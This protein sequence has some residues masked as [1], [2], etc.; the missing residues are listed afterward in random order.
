MYIDNIVINNVGPISNF[1][2]KPKFNNDGSP[3]P[4]VI[5]GDN[6]KGKTALSS[7]VADSLI[8]IA[9]SNGTYQN[10]VEQ[11]GAF[12]K[13]I[14]SKNISN[15]E[16]YS[17]V[18]ISYKDEKN[19]SYVEKSGNVCI[20]NLKND[21]ISNPESTRIEG[22]LREKKFVKEIVGNLNKEDVEKIFN[23][24]VL[25]FFPSYRSEKPVW[26]NENAIKYNE[27]YELS[28]RV[29]GRLDKEILVEHSEERN[30]QWVH[31]VIVDSLIDIDKAKDGGNNF[32]INGNVSNQQLLKIA[33]TNLEKIL[34]L[35][36]KTD[37]LQ[38][39]MNYRNNNNSFRVMFNDINQSNEKDN[40]YNRSINSLKELSLG[41]AVLFNMFATIIRHADINDINNSIE[42]S[43]IQGVVI[44]DEIDMHLDSVMQ[45]EVLPKLLKLFPK[46]QFIITS[47]SPLF[48]LGMDREFKDEYTLLEMPNGT[49]IS[50]ERFSEFEKSYRY[51]NSTK[52]HEEELNKLVEEKINEIKM[53]THSNPLII[54]EGKTDWI[55]L[56]NALNKLKESGKYKDLTLDFLEFDY[57]MG[58][59]ELVKMKNSL[60]KLPQPYKIVLI[61]DRDTNKKEIQDFE[62]N[63]GYKNWN[64]NVYTFRIPIP[65]HRI[66]TPKICIEHFYTDEEIKTEFEISGIRKRL[67][68]ANEF[69]KETG[70]FLGEQPYR[71]KKIK[72]ENPIEII[73][74]SDKCKVT[75]FKDVTQT[76]YA[77][78]KYEFAKRITEC[79][80]VNYEE[81]SLIFDIIEKIIKDNQ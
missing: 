77:I 10:V 17:A 44:V 57:D 75:K 12:Y 20:E 62:T 3:L 27:I 2:F 15:G 29:S 41:Q 74:S 72:Y 37:K 67:F 32:I 53:N 76:N 52:K 5:I 42:L 22:K 69:Q 4:I 55:H 64:N 45:N 79:N 68:M 54:T 43:K 35:I 70:D 71:T 51:L 63:D 7:Y 56:K 36:L 28:Q 21:I 34:K 65:S 66:N 13:I 73:D 30:S 49:E 26:M 9:K 16:E 18:I 60:C 31:S 8:E 81:F 47:H 59:D 1:S 61:A 19:F 25:C 33:K 14:S 38:L 58:E 46:I 23:S 24:N 40:I 6:G 78:S 11:E 80:N 50:T 39:S 48:L